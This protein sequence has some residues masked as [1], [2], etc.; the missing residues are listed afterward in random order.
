MPQSLGGAYCYPSDGCDPIAQ[1]CENAAACIFIGNA[2]TSCTFATEATAGQPCD[3]GTS[4]AAGDQCAYGSGTC[5]Q[6][7]D[8][9]LSPAACATGQTCKDLSA[10]AG[11]TIG[12]CL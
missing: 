12:E 10:Q 5:Y 8:P 4:C 11:I 9:G 2:A 6:L 7:C 3:Y 1:D